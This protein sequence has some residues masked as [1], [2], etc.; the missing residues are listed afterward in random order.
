MYLNLIFQVKTKNGNSSNDSSPD[1]SSYEVVDK[2]KE[3][4]SS[5]K[6]TEQSSESAD[7][8]KSEKMEEGDEN[9]NKEEDEIKETEEILKDK[10]EEEES[11]V[12]Q[13]KV[14]QESNEDLCE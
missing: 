7:D 1:I 9:K 3:K 2:N 6:K 11:G 13:R 12:R 14:H 5:E 4:N 10:Q 8:K